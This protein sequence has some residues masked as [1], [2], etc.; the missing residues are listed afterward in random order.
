MVMPYFEHNPIINNHSTLLIR[1]LTNPSERMQPESPTLLEA[2]YER[3]KTT[4]NHWFHWLRRQAIFNRNPSM[5]CG[6][7]Y[8]NWQTLAG[9]LDLQV[10]TSSSLIVL[11][12][13]L[14]LCP[15]QTNCAPSHQ[16]PSLPSTRHAGTLSLLE[17][18][19]P[20]GSISL[21]PSRR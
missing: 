4:S 17:R 9:A 20:Q 14:S 16:L 8:S 19:S 10:I 1:H 6:H 15:S 12:I 11:S 13:S 18:Y 3:N 21:H 5:V 2:K 7:S